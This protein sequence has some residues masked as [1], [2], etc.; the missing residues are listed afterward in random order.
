MDDVIRQEVLMRLVPRQRDLN[1]EPGAEY[2]Y[3]NTG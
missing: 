3:S 2:L 1:F